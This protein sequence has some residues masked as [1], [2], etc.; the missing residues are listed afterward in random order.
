[1]ALIVGVMAAL[2][3][4]LG[5]YALLPQRDPRA[6]VRQVAGLEGRA[7]LVAARA[8]ARTLVRR[9]LPQLSRWLY[10]EQVQGRW[11]GWTEETILAA[12][13]GVG[14]AALAL[15]YLAQ[16]PASLL[17]VALVT[18]ASVS[19]VNRLHSRFQDARK[20]IEQELPLVAMALATAA[21]RGVPI[22]T[23][24][25]H[26][27]AVEGETLFPRWLTG[28]MA[29]RPAAV[30]LTE[31]LREQARRSGIPALVGFA[32]TLHTIEQRGKG[33]EELYTLAQQVTNAYLAGVQRKVKQLDD[34]LSLVVGL[35]YFIPYVA[36][37]VA[38]IA[39]GVGGW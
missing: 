5:T 11:Q 24:L 38:P 3:V 21:E 20:R 15:V 30:P 4:G 26:L 34:R 32:G 29:S 25:R 23:G 10:W 6:A 33:H 18:L 16:I 12:Q 39:A 1:M 17:S 13:A 14:L 22:A 36:L 37:V 28:A 8:R 9:V 2:A 35:F 27:A 19:L 7:A 31:W